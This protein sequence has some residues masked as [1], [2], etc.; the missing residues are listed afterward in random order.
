MVCVAQ[1]SR[2]S[3]ISACVRAYVFGMKQFNGP[4]TT[5]LFG[6]NST[7]ILLL[8]DVSIVFPVHSVEPAEILWSIYAS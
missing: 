3:S 2:T 6:P 4:Q 1:R 8:V 7:L 5:R